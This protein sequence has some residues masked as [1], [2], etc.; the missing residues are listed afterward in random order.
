MFDSP[1]IFPRMRFPYLRGAALVAVLLASGPSAGAA[2]ELGLSWVHATS[3]NPE[4]PHPTGFE[5]VGQAPHL[6]WLFRVGYTRYSDDTDKTGTVCR[7]YSP[8][9]D[10]GEERVLSSMTLSGVRLGVMRTVDLGPFIRIGGGGG[11]SFSSITSHAES[12]ATGAR[13]DLLQPNAGHIGYQGLVS[14][15]V[16][17]IPGVPLRLHAGLTEHWVNFH[18]CAD[19]TDKTSG[20]APFCGTDR[21]QEI[22]VGLTWD[23][24]GL[25][26]AP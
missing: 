6:G 26:Q 22:S 20:Y 1:L 19:P 15:A 21:F 14:L 18:G 16:T 23:V 12:A 5:V 9:I 13:A 7:V 24:A 11:L 4:L 25:R 10:C 2:Q 3:P 17:P 8:R